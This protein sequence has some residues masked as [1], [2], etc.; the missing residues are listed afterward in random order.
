[1]GHETYCYICGA[2]TTNNN[3]V[4]KYSIQI[5][6]LIDLLEDG[7][8]KDFILN[9]WLIENIIYELLKHEIINKEEYDFY[10]KEENL[11]HLSK[12]EKYKWLSELV[13]LHKSGKVIELK[14]GD[15]W[16][17]IYYDKDKNE[18]QASFQVDDRFGDVTKIEETYDPQS[19]K[20]WFDGYVCHRDCYDLV[21]EIVPNFNLKNCCFQKLDYKEILTYTAQEVPWSMFFFFEKNYMLESPKTNSENKK[22]IND[23]VRTM[24]FHLY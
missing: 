13:I 5:K 6:N 23:L 18:Y 1:M 24:N 7:I 9:N 4:S 3:C 10:L 11:M 17:G 19:D 20:F 16:E 2:P 8:T 14:G 12:E 22:R 15:S 21:E